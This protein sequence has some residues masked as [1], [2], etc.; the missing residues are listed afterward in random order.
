MRRAQ[1]GVICAEPKASH[2]LRGAIAIIEGAVNLLME[3]GRVDLYDSNK[4]ELKMPED[5]LTKIT[6][7]KIVKMRRPWG[8]KEEGKGN[9]EKNEGES[10][11]KNEEEKDPKD[12]KK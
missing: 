12:D 2:P 7:G 9:E 1:P 4:M 8:E 5:E 10:E 6:N 11:E 3:N